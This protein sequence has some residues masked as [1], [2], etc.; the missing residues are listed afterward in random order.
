VLRPDLD[1][2]DHPQLRARGVSEAADFHGIGTYLYPRGPWHFADTEPLAFEPAPKLGQHNREIL[3]G[4]LG[5]TD[6]ELEALEAQ[7]VIGTRPLE[8]ADAPVPVRRH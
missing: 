7:E 8:T 2:H 5:L 4:L 6:A 3:G 1:Q